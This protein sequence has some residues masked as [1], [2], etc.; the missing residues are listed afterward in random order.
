M[1]SGASQPRT[2]ADATRGPRYRS[3]FSSSPISEIEHRHADGYLETDVSEEQY[4]EGPDSRAAL[5]QANEKATELR[6]RAEQV[7]D[8]WISRRRAQ[9]LE[10]QTEYGEA[11]TQAEAAQ[12]HHRCRERLTTVPSS[13][14]DQHPIDVWM[15]VATRLSSWGMLV[16]RG[17]E[18]SMRRWSR[19]LRIRAGG[20]AAAVGRRRERPGARDGE[21]RGED[22]DG[23][24]RD[25]QG[26]DLGREG[27][28]ED[29]GEWRGDECSEK[30]GEHRRER[31]P[32]R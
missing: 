2:R 16:G 10:L 1:A 9:V 5:A 23:D 19:R 30:D 22:R 7:D 27:G 6:P 24:R 31:E 25:L 15:G 32:F 4:R 26:A 28:G 13:R 17:V 29:Q 20:V 18:R 8:E 14:H 12:D 21:V 3:G 11:D